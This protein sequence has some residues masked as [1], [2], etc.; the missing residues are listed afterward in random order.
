MSSMENQHGAYGSF[1]SANDAD[2]VKK[3][4]AFNESKI[5]HGGEEPSSAEGKAAKAGLGTSSG[6]GKDVQE[7]GSKVSEKVGDMLNKNK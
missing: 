2:L 1:G 7:A 3:V 4:N 5:E 6:D